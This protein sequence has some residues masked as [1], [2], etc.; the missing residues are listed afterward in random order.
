[1]LNELDMEHRLT[2]TQLDV[3]HFRNMPG[4]TEMMDTLEY[5]AINDLKEDLPVPCGL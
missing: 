1:M 2:P 4:V 5:F 3:S